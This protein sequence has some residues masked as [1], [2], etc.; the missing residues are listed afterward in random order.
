M[1]EAL[2]TLVRG[3]HHWLQNGLHVADEQDPM[4]ADQERA[5]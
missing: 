5:R 2:V 3:R 1:P 4:V